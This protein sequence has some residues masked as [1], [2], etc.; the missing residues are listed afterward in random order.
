LGIWHY[1]KKTMA[2][3]DCFS[4]SAKLIA[5]L[6]PRGIQSIK[7]C[8]QSKA[9]VTLKTQQ[10]KRATQQPDIAIY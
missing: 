7:Y 9:I 4:H 6:K 1:R 5:Q 8:M 2:I 10:H 3:I